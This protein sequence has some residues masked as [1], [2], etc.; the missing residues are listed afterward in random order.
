LHADKWV[1]HNVTRWHYGSAQSSAV[2][3]TFNG[4]TA[5]PSP[6]QPSPAQFGVIDD[7]F[8]NITRAMESRSLQSNSNT[9][10]DYDDVRLVLFLSTD[11]VGIA[12]QAANMVIY[13]LL[14]LDCQI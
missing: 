5:V 10:D 3:A 9:S 13:Y 6:A 4:V 2:G 7:S 11:D 8:V 14:G 1:H 12:A